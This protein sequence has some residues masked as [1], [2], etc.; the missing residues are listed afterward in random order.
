MIT[1]EKIKEVADKIAREFQPE[2]IILFGSFAWGT[3]TEDSDID[4]LVVKQAEDIKTVR[5]DISISLF[6]RDFSMDLIV[7]TPEQIE[8]RKKIND[9][10]IKEIFTKGQILYG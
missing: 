9:L 3:P 2:K 7:Y 6:P 8:K 10:F 1:R 5:R 4:L